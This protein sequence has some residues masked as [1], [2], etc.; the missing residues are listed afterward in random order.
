MIDQL[1]LFTNN[2]IIEQTICYPDTQS[3]IK[4]ISYILSKL[5][6]NSETI[7]EQFNYLNKHVIKKSTKK[8]NQKLPDKNEIFHYIKNI[9]KVADLSF[10]TIIISLIYVKRLNAKVNNPLTYT[11]WKP[12]ICTSLM[13]ASKVWDDLSMI[14]ID[15]S[16]LFN[17]PLSYINKWENLFLKEL[18]FN[19]NIS[20]SEYSTIYFDMRHDMFFSKYATNLRKTGNMKNLPISVNYE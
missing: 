20:A 18:S 2:L 7:L 16:L 4:A 5:F 14:N 11:N 6:N 10:D 17:Y 19:T 15:F 12:I 9:V 3:Q 13:V 8:I 1:N